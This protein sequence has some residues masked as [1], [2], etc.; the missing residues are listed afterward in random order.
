MSDTS[1]IW[2]NATEIRDLLV[3]D[4]VTPL[5][6]LDALEA[7]VTEVEPKINALPTLCFERAR[8]NAK[9]LMEK[10]AGDRGL[11]M[12]MPVAIKDLEEVKGVRT[13][14]GSPIFADHIPDKS[15]IVVETLEKNGGVVYAKANT[16][17]FGAGGNTFNE[18]L[19]TTLNPWNQERSVA[20]SSGGSAAALASGTAWLAQG[21]DTGGS[22]RN[23]ASFC[24]IVGMRP[25]PGRVARGPSGTP[26]ANLPVAGPMART[27]SDVAL[28]L[29]AM[30]GEHPR[31]PISLAR[32][33]ESF[34]DAVKAARLPKRV[35]FSRDLGCTPVDPE[36]AKICETAA[37]KFESLGVKVEEA[38]PDFHDV[39]DI[40]QA[41]RAE[42][43]YMTKHK[44]LAEHRDKLKPEVVWNIEKALD[45]SI[46]DFTR[47]ELARGAYIQRAV[48]FFETYDLLLSPATCVGPYP[49][50]QRYV[51]QCDGHKF[52]NYVEW[53]TMAYA[54]TLTTF[55]ALSMPA[56]FT[57]EGL[58][59]GLQVVGGPRGEAALL[60]AA[61]LLEPEIGHAGAVPIDPI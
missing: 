22:L 53:L 35:A 15:D 1:L 32:P 46:K 49:V 50:E 58:P 29:D 51:E 36:V 6:L 45:Y 24:S 33:S 11:L 2:K 60:S 19:G 7:R 27:V 3:K 40:F 8:D 30:V 17:E 52:D 25:S 34:V 9:A 26:F 37:L 5:D 28:M 54:I 47:V 16:P 44:L 57:S 55:P 61:A 23:P 43:F 41:L 13:T 21:S 38:H 31:D 4:E 59:V 20:G 18:V 12:G 14:F 56:G 10:P 39:Q 48:D 42:A